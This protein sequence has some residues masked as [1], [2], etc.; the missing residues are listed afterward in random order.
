MAKIVVAGCGHGGLV[1]AT[2]LARAGHEVTVY[3]KAPR[4]EIGHP[5]SDAFDYD[6]FTYA[7]LPV[8]PYFR[9]GGNVITFV[10]PGADN[11][12]LTIPALENES[13]IVDRKELINYLVE[14]AEEAGVEILF[15]KEATAPIILGNR[16]AGIVVDGEKIYC[17]MVIDA[18]GVSSP[19]RS[20]LP[21]FMGVNRAVEKYDV[22]HSYRAYFSRTDAPDPRHNYQLYLQEDGTVGFSWLITEIDRTD[23]LIC[24]FYYP[25]DS[26]VLDA[27]RI[28]QEK[29]PQMGKDMIY[30][31]S[32]SVIPVCQ[33]LGML[34]ADG[35]AAVGDSAF[36][37]IPVKGSG[38]TYSIKAGK[39]LADC[40]LKDTEGFFDT[41]SLW[42]YQR[43]FFKELGFGACHLA[44]IKNILPYLTT[45]QVD[46]I[47]RLK[48]VST[49]E[50]QDIMSNTA[51]AIFTP[52]GLAA[53]REKIRL[54]GNNTVIKD[55]LSSI[56]VWIG[57]FFVIEAAFPTKYDRA[58]IQKWLRRY[59]NFFVSIKKPE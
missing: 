19:I 6:T 40:I 9:R 39:M 51:N 47:F 59:N 16:V 28:V 2:K 24:R 31:G 37:T 11:E 32:R 25:E 43:R 36:M 52:K 8:A 26:E 1:A 21:D 23:A 10:P 42:E 48:L 54:A 58:D 50:I 3:E 22:V 34:V 49:E 17:D 57:K 12:P 4:Q 27:L 33:P 5:Q 44:I 20:Q 45:A 14:L 7:D 38:I 41:E 55:I 56:A 13:Y 46:E 18:C 30:G 53:T 15:E 29:N 35:Y